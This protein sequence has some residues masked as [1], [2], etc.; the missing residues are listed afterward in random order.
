MVSDRAVARKFMSLQH[1][2]E[3]RGID[4]NLSLQSVRNILNA[5]RC[6]YTG[7]PLSPGN[8]SVDRI[9]ND[10]G[11]VKGNVAACDLYFNRRKGDLN[12]KEIAI[13]AR[14]VL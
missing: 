10:R 13:L 9:D 5:K 12:K 4:F 3:H 11:Y 14:K 2:A 8:L 1:S 7:I 6:Y